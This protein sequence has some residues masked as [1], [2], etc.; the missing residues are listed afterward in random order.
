ML[1][2]TWMGSAC[3]VQFS[4]LL[5][6]CLIWSTDSLAQSPSTASNSAIDVQQTP[7]F[8]PSV[9]QTFRTLARPLSLLWRDQPLKPGLQTIASTQGVEIFL[10]RR[11]DPTQPVQIGL[12]AERIDILL[13]GIANGINCK[14]GF[15]ESVAY[16]GPV[17]ETARIE[18]TYW[19]AWYQYRK[20]LIDIKAAGDVTKAPQIPVQK[21]HWDRLTTPQEI[22]YAIEREWNIEILGKEKVP[23]DLWDE[24]K[25]SALTLPAQIC[26]VVAGFGLSAE[27]IPD[28]NQWKLIAIRDSS[29][30]MLGYA[31]NQWKRE[32]LEQWSKSESLDVTEEAKQYRVRADVA[33]HYA[34]ALGKYQSTLP[35]PKSR[36]ENLRFTFEAVNTPAADV[37]D[38]IAIQL[39]LQADWQIERSALA[40]RRIGLKVNQ[41]SVKQL[42]EEL[43]KQSSVT[44]EVVNETTLIIKP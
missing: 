18:M 38:S 34:I 31:K 44:L 6:G 25:Y 26:L 5:S 21:L 22:L 1:R 11:I 10:D 17:E 4:L 27:P 16:I 8:Q 35:K 40:Q 42:I 23:H 28:T 43:A 37:I 12:G 14:L 33:T 19:R 9:Q 15:I 36:F 29:N 30:A 7:I 2:R 32:N 39:Q 3:V 41:A 20:Q 24:G 13:K